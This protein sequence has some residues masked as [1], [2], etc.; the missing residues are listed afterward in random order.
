M[1]EVAYRGH[2]LEVERTDERDNIGGYA[3][4]FRLHLN[5][6]EIA[7]ASEIES[8]GWENPWIPTLIQYGKAY[9]DGRASCQ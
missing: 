1:K 6:H 7:T 2:S 3:F 9:V 8:E 4:E 5:G